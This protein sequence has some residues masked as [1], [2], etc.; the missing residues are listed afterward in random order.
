MGLIPNTNRCDKVKIAYKKVVWDYR[1][2]TIVVQ[3]LWRG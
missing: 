2:L 1:I 3:G